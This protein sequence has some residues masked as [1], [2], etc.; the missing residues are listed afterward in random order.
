MRIR[1]A[2]K[3][4]LLLSASAVLLA[5]LV[6]LAVWPAPAACSTGA[7]APAQAV[8]MGQAKTAFDPQRVA[9]LEKAGWEAY[10]DRNWPQVLTLMV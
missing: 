9:Y 4:V 1:H 8:A 3:R 7:S 2:N 5:V 10:Y 6:A